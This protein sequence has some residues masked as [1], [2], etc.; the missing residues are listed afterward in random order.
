[1]KRS[2]KAGAPLSRSSAR[3][4]KRTAPSWG[5]HE[6]L[7]LPV[8]AAAHRAGGAA[9]SHRVL[10][11]PDELRGGRPAHR[12]ARGVLRSACGRWGRTDRH[13]GALHPPHG[14]AVR[15]VDPRL[16]P[17]RSS[18]ATG[19]SPKRCI[20]TARRS[21]PRSTTTAARGRACTAGCRCGRRRRWP[22]RCSARCRRRSTGARSPR[23]SPA[24]RGRRTL[25]GG[26]VRRHR[27]A[28]LAQLDRARLPLACHERPHGRVRRLAREPGPA[29]AARS[30]PRC[31]RRSAATSR[32]AS[33]CAATSSSR[34]A[35]PS[36]TRST[37]RAMVEAQG[38]T[39]YLNTS[40][41]VATASLYMIE[42][43]MQVPPGYA[44]FIPSAL[45]KAVDLPVVGR[46]TLQGSA[47]GGACAGRRSL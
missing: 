32:S 47:A 23:S 34:A 3:R 15:E 5:R 44:L 19:A 21:S 9:Q 26:R 27:A 22:T 38:L 18:P 11:S 43:S 20:A 25:Q 33:G 4:T 1:M 42:A 29:A 39:D 35:P 37:S 13:R 17:G 8:L 41:G 7:P 24:T 30:S 40:I 28:V 36:T 31:A 10:R 6:P 2:S 45:R 16:P 46:R 14:L 12:A